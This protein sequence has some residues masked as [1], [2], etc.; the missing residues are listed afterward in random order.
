MFFGALAS[1]YVFSSEAAVAVLPFNSGSRAARESWGAAG[2]VVFT[3][4]IIGLY[5][6]SAFS[7]PDEAPAAGSSEEDAPARPPRRRKGE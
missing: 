2:A 4:L 7:E 5:V 3:N 6:W 1:F